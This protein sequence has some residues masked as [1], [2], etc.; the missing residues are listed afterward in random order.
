MNFDFEKNLELTIYFTKI[1]DKFYKPH[2]I[3]FLVTSFIVIFYIS[4][5]GFHVTS[6][7]ITRTRFTGLM[8]QRFFQNHFVFFPSQIWISYDITPEDLKRCVL[9]M[10]DD[11]FS[12]HRGVDWESLELAARTN[13]RRGKI[14]RGGSTITMQLAKNI[15]FTTS[16]NY[17]R[18]TKEIITAIRM[19]K[20]LDKRIILEQYLNVIELGKRIFGAET[21]SRFYYKKS[22]QNLSRRDIARLVA[23]IPSP[24]KYSPL[25]KRRFVNNRA[26]L[27]LSRMDNS[28]L[29]E[30]K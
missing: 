23:I 25:D 5:P 20:E 27:A 3:K 17:F 11:A 22:V 18:K 2:R 4:I 30:E 24:L 7:E 6:L 12:F 26:A 13:I 16:R 28:I 19:E 29:P 10:E 15:Y 21:A 14:V 1:V 8:E 9:T